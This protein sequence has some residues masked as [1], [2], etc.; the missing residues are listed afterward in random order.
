MTI[1][2]LLQI[3]IL[4][5]LIN[6]GISAQCGIGSPTAENVECITNASYSFDLNFTISDSALDSFDVYNNGILVNRYSVDQL[7]VKVNNNV[8]TSFSVD[9]FK[10]IDIKSG[11]HTNLIVPNPC[12]S[13]VFDP[14]YSKIDCN[15]DSFYILLNF[16]HI[17]N[18]DTFEIGHQKKYFGK[19]LYKNLPVTIGPFANIDTIYRPFIQ[20]IGELFCLTDFVVNSGDC[21][22]CEINNLSLDSYTCDDNYNKNISFSFDHAN[23]GTKGYDVYVN[24]IKYSTFDFNNNTVIDTSFIRDKFELNSVEIECEDTLY[25]KLVDVENPDCSFESKFTSLCCELCEIGEI[26]I[27]NK[28]CTSDSTFNFILDFDFAKNR[29]DSFTLTLDGTENKY[30]LNALPLHFN[31][32]QINDNISASV[33]LDGGKC[34]SDVE[35]EAPDCD[36]F[37]CNISGALY[38]ITYD[39]ISKYWVNINELVHKSTSDSFTLAGN[40]TKYGIFSYAELPIQLGPYTCADSL[41]LEYLFKDSKVDDCTYVI[42]PGVIDCP[43]KVSTEDINTMEN[44]NIYSDA[45]SLYIISDKQKFKNASI[46]IYDVL[47]KKVYRQN[48][49]TGNKYF[50]K[51]I[52]NLNSGIYILYFRNKDYSI[53]KKIYLGK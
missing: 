37:D 28:E 21:P 33:C 50:K 34:C 44:W 12:E 48:L 36:Y 1:S 19:H 52:S 29:K 41:N 17:N 39:S 40:G 11:C 10:L 9:T 3:S 25:I 15:E 20:D 35:F 42:E 43:F 14:V 2:K 31:N 16:K 46:C 32:Y 8:Y 30:N 23:S 53:A 13:A 6:F 24:E 45:K 26:D 18:S 49:K 22:Q 7:P 38:S 27:R 51:D 4:I 5:H 47:G